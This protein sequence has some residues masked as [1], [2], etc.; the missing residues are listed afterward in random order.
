[1]VAMVGERVV[2]TAVGLGVVVMGVVDGGT[3]VLAWTGGEV[4]MDVSVGGSVGAARR[5]GVRVSDCLV[6]GGVNVGLNLRW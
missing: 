3:G 5:V 4:L 6:A 1:M 2:G